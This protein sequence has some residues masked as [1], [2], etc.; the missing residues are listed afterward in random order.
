MSWT[1]CNAAA[2][3][4]GTAEPRLKTP[5]LKHTL[6]RDLHCV[7]SAVLSYIVRLPN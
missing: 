4:Q 2:D 1:P 3:H 5:A 6:I 7:H